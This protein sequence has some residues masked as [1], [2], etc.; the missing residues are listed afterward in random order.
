MFFNDQGTFLLDLGNA[1]S[2]NSLGG[3]LTGI[4]SKEGAAA[5]V[6]KPIPKGARVQFKVTKTSAYPE[7]L[8]YFR[9]QDI[10]AWLVSKGLATRSK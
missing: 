7:G 1:T 5:A 9:G 3:K 10:A 2:G 6:N 8:L 4:I